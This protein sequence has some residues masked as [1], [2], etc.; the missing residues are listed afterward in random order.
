MLTDQ[1]QREI[2]YLRE[3]AAEHAHKAAQ[4]VYLD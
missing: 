3:R 1:Q 4:P 2:D